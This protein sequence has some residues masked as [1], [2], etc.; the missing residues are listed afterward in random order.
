[1]QLHGA[2]PDAMAEAERA[3][4]LLT[5]P[6]DQWLVGWAWYQQA[7]L[8]RLRGE[9]GDAEAAY[10]Q[11]SQQGHEPQPGLALL[12]LAQASPMLRWRRSAG[13]WTSAGQRASGPGCSPRVLE[14]GSPATTSKLL[15]LRPP[16]C[17]EFAADRNAP[18]LDAMSAHA[19]GEVLLAEGDARAAITTLRRAWMIWQQFEAPYEERGSAR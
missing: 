1:M 17:A 10:R 16:S 8:H 18:V 19:I 9:L 14:I 5:R 15:G 3:R 2:W 11:A 4:D 7:E 12:R 13:V 6:G